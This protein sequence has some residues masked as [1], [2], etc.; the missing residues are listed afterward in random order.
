MFGD[1]YC[2]RSP[3]DFLRL[4]IFGLLLLSLP[5]IA[6]ASNDLGS[7]SSKGARFRFLSGLKLQRASMLSKDDDVK[8]RSLNGAGL[9]ALA[10]LSIGSFIFGAGAT[11]TKFYQSTDKDDVSGTDTSGSLLQYQAAAGFGLGKFCLIGR[12]YFGAD[13][14][15]SQKTDA[16]D[17]SSYSAP[18][19]SYGI[20]LLYRTGGRS[21]WSVDYQSVHFTKAKI[22]GV[23]RDRSSS[24]EQ[25]TLDAIG[26]GY[27]F[28]F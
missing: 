3:G 16:G 26:I 22:G 14:Q 6:L 27:G 4:L 15:L 12:Y 10:G 25:I 21:F 2:V 23:N 7:G 20:S 8:K 5:A 11:F 1:L 19:A 18:E 28:M 24:D 9:D 17:R 13:Y